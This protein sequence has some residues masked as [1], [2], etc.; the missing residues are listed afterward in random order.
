MSLTP[1]P[2]PPCTALDALAHLEASTLSFAQTLRSLRRHM[3]H[4]QTCAQSA[5]CPLWVHVHARLLTAIDQV[6]AAWEGYVPVPE[7]LA[8]AAECGS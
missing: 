1:S 6:S 8:L 3:R 5:T 2:Y 4:C 7:R